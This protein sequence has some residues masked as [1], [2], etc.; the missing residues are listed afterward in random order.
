MVTSSNQAG[1]ASPARRIAG[2]PRFLLRQIRAWRDDL[3]FIAIALVLG[4]AFLIPYSIR[5]VPAGS[6]GVEWKRFAGGTVT[7][8]VFSEG[9]R[10]V[11]PWNK[12]FLYDVRIQSGDNVVSALSADGLQVEVDLAW[13]FQLVPETAGIVHKAVGP[14]YREKVF[15]RVVESVVRDKISLFRSEELHSPERATFEK[16]VFLGV[17]AELSRYGAINRLDPG[18]VP[19]EGDTIS[20]D[21][22]L[23]WVNLEAMLIK[24]VRFPPAVQEAYIRKNTAR[25]LVDEYKFRVAVEQMEVERKM[26]EALGIRNFQEVVNQSLS[27]PYLRWKTLE[28]YVATSRALAQSPN[29]KLVVM[30]PGTG[31]GGM[32]VILDTGG[33]AAAPADV[34][35]SSPAR[36]PQPASGSVLPPTA[37]RAGGPAAQPGLPIPAAARPVFEASATKSAVPPALPLSLGRLPEAK[38]TD[39]RMDLGA[40]AR[41]ADASAGSGGR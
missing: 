3:W 36:L 24:E 11:L 37:D 1:T 29:S 22:G 16:N 38:P 20:L 8:S 40:V 33:L 35:A 39:A 32:P 41:Q 28:A 31:V 13:V 4:I 17:Q 26:V 14:D 10:F 9:A 30:G 15:V 19:A 23:N 34:G 18:Y 2:Y 5:N 6:V 27:E 7:D 25:A 21:K 12:L